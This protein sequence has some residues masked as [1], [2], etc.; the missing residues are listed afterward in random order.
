MRILQPVMDL[1]IHM[2]DTSY[3][4]DDLN[5]YIFLVHLDL[6]CL[7]AQDELNTCLCLKEVEINIKNEMRKGPFP[8]NFSTASVSPF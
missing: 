2:A 6:R 7:Y 4:T 1:I 5:C 3:R 8:V